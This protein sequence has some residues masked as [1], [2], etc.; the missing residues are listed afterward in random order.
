MSFQANFEVHISRDLSRDMLDRA[1]S[2]IFKKL[3]LESI[4]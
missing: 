2:T 4:L 1:D 3:A